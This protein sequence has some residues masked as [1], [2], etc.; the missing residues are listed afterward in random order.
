[1]ILE[2]K[3]T[4]Q[5][6][7][8]MSLLLITHIGNGLVE[9][10]LNRPKA[11]AINH[12][13]VLELTKT[14]NE[15]ANNTEVKGVYLIGNSPFFSAGLDVIEL[16]QYNEKQ[17]K[18]FW[19]DFANMTK[20]LS[21]FPK[22][23][24]AAISGHSPAGGCVL[25]LCADYRIMQEGKFKIGLNEVAV[26]VVVP[27]AIFE[28][29]AFAIGQ[30]KAYQALLSANMFTVEEAKQVGLVH[31][32]CDES[33]LIPQ[34]QLVLSKLCLFETNT[35]QLSKQ[36]LKAHLIEKL[37]PTE[38]NLKATLNHWWSPEGRGVIEGLIANL[39]KK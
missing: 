3:Q 17:I 19:F 24:V 32:T 15:L 35:W 10:K 37:V 7:Y 6:I 28:L 26:G 27:N 14:F 12:S 2:I 8:K 9:I 30:Q 5:N 4:L 36:G 23:F 11:N 1:M 31:H 22:P 13:M 18:Q 16:F 25:A 34:A 20:V 39:T 29:Y 21:A 33:E 38:T